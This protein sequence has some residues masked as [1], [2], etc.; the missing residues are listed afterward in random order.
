MCERLRRPAGHAGFTLI[1][2]MIVIAIIG[3]LATV[4]I[5]AYQ[6]YAVR[7]KMADPINMSTGAIAQVSEYYAAQGQWPTHNTMAGLVAP[8][9][10]TSAYVRS[11]TVSG[12]RLTVLLTQI[13]AGIIPT[14]ATVSFVGTDA[15]GSIR[16]KCTTAL[17]EKYVPT[18]C[19]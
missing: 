10:F 9:S 8:T 7:A 17:A 19:R 14:G 6:D 18:Q 13:K 11:L 15:G 12:T 1:E 4:A 3:V 5:P 16:W 2:L